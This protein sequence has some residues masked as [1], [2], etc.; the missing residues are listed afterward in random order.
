MP[1][2]RVIYT[3]EILK[4]G[5]CR[6]S[7]FYSEAEKWEADCDPDWEGNFSI[8]KNLSWLRKCFTFNPDAMPEGTIVTVFESGEI[9]ISDNLQIARAGKF[10]NSNAVVQPATEYQ[11]RWRAK[12]LRRDKGG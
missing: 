10:D 1:K 5:H 3:C 9:K 12:Q 6:V 8:A 4:R 11:R 7:R 2:K